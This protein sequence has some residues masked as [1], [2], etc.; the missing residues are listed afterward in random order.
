MISGEFAG[1]E[2]TPMPDILAR[3]GGSE[4]PKLTLLPLLLL[5]LLLLVLLPLLLLLLLLL[6]EA[7]KGSGLAAGGG[8]GV[9]YGINGAGGAAGMSPAP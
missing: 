2:M 3:S 9:P 7:A 1:V 6:P 4:N 8:A 5:L